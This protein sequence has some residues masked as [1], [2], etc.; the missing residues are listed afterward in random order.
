[1]MNSTI[2]TPL[3]E[4]RG[5]VKEYDQGRVKAL[6][7]LD[8]TITEGEILAIM[9][10]SGSGKSTLLQML[11]AL[12]RPTSGKLTFAGV[13][14][15]DLPSLSA[16]RSREIGFIFQSFHLIP[17]LNAIE[18]VQVPM[19]ESQAGRA[20]R[21]RRAEELLESVGLKDRLHHRP[22]QMSGGERQ[23]VAVARSLANGPRLL[24]ADEPTGNLDSENAQRILDVL[25]EAHAKHHTTLVIVT[26]D[27]TVALRVG[28]TVR[29]FDGQILVP[30]SD[31]A[32]N[33]EVRDD[34]V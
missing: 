16:F 17:T 29:M 12:D 23:R 6:R 13:S 10:P 26:H 19:L 18:N 4:A 11:G 30:S 8:L 2:G 15:A 14:I 1:M 24:L 25:C 22:S 31:M 28:R 33:P 9:G 32:L 5:L 27:P 20:E 3:I 21:K 34:V 7:G